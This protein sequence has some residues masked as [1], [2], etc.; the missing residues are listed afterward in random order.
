MGRR[1]PA[2]VSRPLSQ[3]ARGGGCP[4]IAITRKQHSQSERS[5]LTS[6]EQAVADKP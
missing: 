1:E 2:D 4:T 6:V 5:Q 3:R